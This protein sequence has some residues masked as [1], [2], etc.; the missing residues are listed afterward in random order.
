M[1]ERSFDMSP[2]LAL[3]LVLLL[4]F[5][6]LADSRPAVT[7]PP[8]ASRPA[9]ASNREKPP[10]PETAP[11]LPDGT[12]EAKAAIATLQAPEEFEIEVYA[13]EPQ[14]G[15]PVAI[16]LDEHN[17]VYVAE[18]YRFNRGTEE[19]RTRPFLL[20]DDLQLNTVDDRLAMYRKWAGKFEGGMD[21]FTR[22]TDQVRR[23]EDTN[24]DGVADRSTIFASGFNHPLDG[25]AAGVIAR[26]GKVWLTCIPH[27][28]L[29]EDSDRDGVAEKRTALHR[30][31]GV[32][33]AFLGH[34]LHGLV[35][36]PDGRLYF[37]VGDRGFHVKTHEGHTLH[38]PRRGAVFRCEPDGASLE[39]IHVGLRNPQELAFD[40]FGNLFAA[41]NNCDKGDHSRL[42]Y[43]ME[44]ADSGWNMA[45]QTIPEPYLVGPWH[46]EKMWHLPHAGQPAWLLP[47]VGSLGAGPSGFAYCPGTGLP[48]R[49]AGRFFM[50]NYT[51]NGG[52]EE[53][54]VQPRGAGFEKVD[55]QDFLKPIRATDI[56]FGTDGRI[57][58][59]DFVKLEWNGPGGRGRIY[60]LHDPFQ[61]DSFDVAD[62]RELFRTG[63]G[64]RSGS[65]L[66]RLLGHADL[67][68][69]Q[70]AQFALAERGTKVIGPLVRV[71]KKTR[72]P[73]ARRHAVW[74]LW[75]IGRQQ[76]DVLAHLVP[77]V[78]DTEAEIRAQAVRVLGDLKYA[79]AAEAIAGRLDDDS[80]RVQSFAAIATGRLQ[81]QAAI[82]GLFRILK[83]NDNQDPWLR[84]AAVTGLAGLNNLD[85]VL[86]R[87]DD[88]SAAVRLG[89][90][91]VLRRAQDPRISRFLHDASVQLVTEAA[92][93]INDVPLDQ[94][95]PAL[96]EVMTRLGHSP[97]P[98]P[99]AL[100]RR[101]IHACFRLGTP[102]HAAA[103]AA[104]A[105]NPA[106]TDI[107]RAEAVA[108]LADWSKPAQR[109][110][111]N[112]SWRP[113]ENREPA[114]VRQGVERHVAA[115]L[116]SCSGD[117]LTAVTSLVDR[118][119]VEADEETFFAWLEDSQQQESTRIAAFNLLDSRDS[120]SLPNAI[121]IA[122]AAD[123]AKLRARARS[124]VARR[125][126][127]RGLKLLSEVLSNVDSPVLER[128][129][130]VETLA[131]LKEPQAMSLL[132]AWAAR[133]LDG[134]V[135]PELQLDVYEALATAGTPAGRQA[136]QE[137]DRQ[138]GAG[139][140]LE[141]YSLVLEGGDS[142]RG[143][144]IFVG[145]RVAQCIRCHRVGTAGGTAGPELTRVAQ[146]NPRSHLLESLLDP[147]AKIAKGFGTVALVLTSG[148][149][150]TG[151]LLA[152]TPQAITLQLSTGEKRI[153][154]QAE[155]EERSQPKSPM[156]EVKKVLTLREIRDL[157]AW[158]ATLK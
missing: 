118:L 112:G 43:V 27:L 92:R 148:K 152:E 68:V 115:L 6:V 21:W 24:N 89:V 124:V 17:R 70:R 141:Q 116:A 15:S 140:L 119:G 40:E 129:Q 72:E 39:L 66:L 7:A 149:V 16:C 91:L 147:N 73:L 123:S 133:L 37:S 137:F 74:A 122:L 20:E 139:K 125:D 31:F 34:D 132:D 110:R 30:G 121:K 154:P 114:I 135:E 105:A 69:R 136:R 38:G 117:L 45:F 2:R 18:Q 101:A 77:L 51:G 81:H 60:T 26:D 85:A 103:V 59:S 90:L 98:E 156:P 65:E 1:P 61:V 71:F 50:C 87:A 33:A 42:V 144:E 97:Q 8:A 100:A 113:L 120:T 29:L 146:K 108:A 12:A 56:D 10:V 94:A 32:N 78:D 95:T 19:N 104:F 11:L 145:H 107:A 96:A 5:L 142:S 22:V 150:L 93:A 49:F 3:P 134:E 23:L 86:T 128:Q 13:A 106:N 80:P 138:R 44:G 151:N 155:I 153:I 54:G 57:Y 158:L 131:T 48:E 99:D 88:E 62:V 63:F 111:V 52:I 9:T 46:A 36:G 25:L 84:H 109:D 53:F 64:S 83:E 75:Q 14:L 4:L 58:V 126:A 102:D 41:D 157:V 76:P 35:W 79:P 55:Q 82:D 47:P 67:R 127:D 130:A 143:R 28:W